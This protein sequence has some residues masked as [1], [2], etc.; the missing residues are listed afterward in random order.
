MSRSNKYLQKIALVTNKSNISLIL[1]ASLLIG[2]TKSMDNVNDP[3]EPF[4]RRVYKFNHAVDVAC[5]KPAAQLYTAVLPAKVRSGINN[6]YNN[7]NMLPT[8][9]NDI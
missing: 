5:L 9:A 8:V 2:C 4:N 7:I 1:F 3:Y 6:V